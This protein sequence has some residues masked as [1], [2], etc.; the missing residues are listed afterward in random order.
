MSKTTTTNWRSLKALC[1]A[2]A[3]VFSLLVGI[4]IM[5]ITAY[6]E[7][8][9]DTVVKM[10]DTIDFGGNYVLINDV[11]NQINTITTY[12]LTRVTD[13][14]I[15]E[16][17]QW[18]FR[19]DNRNYIYISGNSQQIP[20]GFK[21]SG[22]TGTQEDPYT[23][24]LVFGDDTTTNLVGSIAKLNDTINFGE[25]IVSTNDDD[26][27]S[28][29]QAISIKIS[30]IEWNDHDEQ[31]LFKDDDYDQIFYF[32]GTA[33]LI[34]VGFYVS[35]GDGSE[36]NPYTLAMLYEGD[37]VIV[38]DFLP[39]GGTGTMAKAAYVAGKNYTLPE[40]TFIEPS[41]QTFAGWKLENDEVMQAGEEI[42]LSV[43]YSFTAT[44]QGAT[45]YTVTFFGN[46]GKWP[47]G[48]TQKTVTI[49]PGSDVTVP[50]GLEYAG[51]IFVE[52]NT[53]QDGTGETAV[54]TNI[55]T[56][57][58]FYAKWE[59]DNL[60]NYTVTFIGNGGKWLDGATFKEVPVNKKGKI[61]IP[62]EP[63]YEG[64]TFVEW[65]TKDDGTGET[66]VLTNITS[67]RT[68]YA[69]WVDNGST[70]SYIVTFIGNGGKWPDDDTKK[71]VT[72]NS[73]SDVAAPG[74]LEYEGYTFD[75]WNTKDDGTGETA[76]LTNITSNKT[77]YAK[78]K[79]AEEYTISSDDVD[80]NL[81]IQDPTLFLVA[82]VKE[83][84]KKKTATITFKWN[85]VGGASGYV[86]YGTSC[87]DGSKL[88]KIT[89]LDSKKKSY[90]LSSIEWN[91]CYKY[92]VKA[93]D[94]NGKVLKESL[95]AHVVV[96]SDTETNVKKISA[97]NL[98]LTV[99]NESKI[100]ATATPC[101]KTRKTIWEGHIKNQF[102][103]YSS[104]KNI[105]TVTEDGKI[106]AVA[107][108]KVTIYVIASNGVKKAVKVTIK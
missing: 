24:A 65:N 95:G 25:A 108:G 73:G 84:A 107:E 85:K 102:R 92:V 61:I 2:L 62:D 27:Y 57:K 72:V 100:V 3:M 58:K 9:V 63:K 49:N 97:K 105:A 44:W 5:P 26:K 38:F 101:N 35:G 53:K 70:S 48:E 33:S 106:T 83:S 6:A 82:N 20:T 4:T 28:S 94:S 30:S 37:T 18:E 59:K 40:C 21:V 78:W 15:Y 87:N 75:G 56:T 81:A 66:A 46:G 74:G 1:M 93:V 99:G 14:V 80:T 17:G 52:W 89:T 103:Y 71:E 7:T 90:K 22:G 12:S 68:Y 45:S 77:F 86:L 96:G 51:Y 42:S 31:W 67:N 13:N 50:S 16:K 41:G 98:K 91:K 39:G 79:K 8:I 64:Y 76:E 29:Y 43:N 10:G 55:T 60:E 23:L 19:D 32:S 69:I 34:P 11:E 47:D 104:N 36:D 88:V 54:F